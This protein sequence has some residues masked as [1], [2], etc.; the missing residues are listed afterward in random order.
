M[1]LPTFAALLLTSAALPVQAQ[2]LYHGMTILDPDT[3]T[4][5]PDSYILVE[6]GMIVATG[7]GLPADTDAATPH[8]FTGMWALPGLI[9]THAHLTLGPTQVSV[10]DGVPVMRAIADD[11]IVA[12]RA[13]MMLSYGVTTARNPG[14]SSSD[15]ARYVERINSGELI[16]PEMLWAGEIIDRG[17]ISIENLSTLVTPERG[18][19]DIVAEQAATGASYIKLYTGLDETDLH[20]GILAA[21]ANG[22]QTIGHLDDVSWTTAAKLGIDSIVHAM[23]TSPELLPEDRREAYVES[24]RPGTFQFFEWYETADLETPAI[25]EM[26]ATLARRGVTFDATLVAFEPAFNGDDEALLS[27]LADHAH[28]AMVENWRS[29]FRFDLGWTAEDYQR[30]RAVWPKV[31]RFVQMMHEGGVSMTIGTDLANPFVAP[32]LA[33]SREMVLHQQAGIPAA[34]VIRMAT[35]DAARSLGLEDRIGAIRPG[36]EADVLFIAADPRPDLAQLAN[37]S[38]VLNDGVLLSSEELRQTN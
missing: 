24:H 26:I 23:P 21:Q 11:D 31:L 16:G 18:V 27:S 10:D 4:A 30:A 14:G 13:R 12:H 1:R 7:E 3:G 37:V 22:L 6:D 34:E 33:L 8:D 19:A 15:N 28:P 2:D 17:P 25:T 5:T 36:M 29:G 32:G 20:E 35:S 9:D 38:S